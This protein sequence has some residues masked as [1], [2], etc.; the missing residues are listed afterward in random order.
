MSSAA[1]WAR[2]VE[3]AEKLAAG[4]PDSG[5]PVDAGEGDDIARLS[6]AL[7]AI[8]RRLRAPEQL[9][10]ASALILADRLSTV[11]RL[12]AALTH[13]LGTPL[14]VVMG[15]A[16]LIA[17]RPGVP[18]ECLADTRIIAEQ[19]R[20][21]AT[22]IQ[23][24]LDYVRRGTG[25]RGTVDVRAFLRDAIALVEPL[26][27]KK[28]VRIVVA[29]DEP[30]RQVRIEA[31]GGRLTQLL[32]NLVLNAV[33]VTS[34]GGIVRVKMDVEPCTPPEKHGGASAE[35]VCFEVRDEGAGIEP[36][37]LARVREPFFTTREDSAGLGLAAAER[38]VETYGG[39]LEIESTVGRGTRV[40]VC[41][42]PKA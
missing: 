12:A 4:E 19:A 42:P 30:D 2:I 7:D 6:R 14:N 11:G 27:D 34:R 18:E 33:Q 16:S 13:D 24:L 39:W 23:R 15:R 26:A 8:A 21:M 36:E 29:S 35:F 38:I 32:T 9:Q 25:A 40:R 31:E 20:R 5:A 3:R 17:T 28:G 22:M 37:R 41:V 1:D 10:P